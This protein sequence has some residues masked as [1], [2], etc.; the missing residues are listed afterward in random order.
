MIW[1]MGEVVDGVLWD[2]CRVL[3]VMQDICVDG[4]NDGV[5]SRGD[6]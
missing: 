4:L 1:K 2:R 5:A 6:M 3:T